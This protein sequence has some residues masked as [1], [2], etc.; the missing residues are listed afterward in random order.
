MK[1]NV[2]SVDRLSRIVLGPV[3]LTLC[4]WGRKLPGAGLGAPL[5]TG[6]VSLC[7]RYKLPGIKSEL[8]W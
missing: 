5:A 4:L 2:G 3:L 7:P 8:G 6:L 1:N